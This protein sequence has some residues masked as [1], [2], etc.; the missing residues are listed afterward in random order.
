MNRFKLGLILA[1]LPI[2]FLSVF[3]VPES[4]LGTLL[5]FCAV[6]SSLSGL[7]ILVFVA[8]RRLQ[9][10]HNWFRN[11]IDD[12]R[13]TLAA[14]RRDL[15][16]TAP[17]Y[18][19]PKLL[20]LFETRVHSQNG[21]DGVIA[22]VFQRIGIENQCFVEIGASDGH[23]NNSALLVQLGWRGLWVEGDSNAT[24]RARER[25]AAEIRADRLEVKNALVTAENIEDLLTD[26]ALPTEFDLFSIDVDGNDYHL[27]EAI[28]RFRPRA[29]VIEYNAAIPPS[30]D[31][32]PDYDPTSSWDGTSWSG[33]SLAALERLG[34]EKGY[35]LVGCETSGVNAVFVLNELAQDRFS[36]PYTAKHHYQPPRYELRYAFRRR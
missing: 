36:S 26:A 7:L 19:D 22:E 10:A 3:D 16:L 23:E 6:S 33:A 20:N 8:E 24:A 5:L 31:W 2:G 11:A 28:R 35:S 1:L 12:L 32:V 4:G 27:W 21:E 25:F 9:K 30:V 18:Q 17:R 15:L 14:H 13:G 34:R 29:V